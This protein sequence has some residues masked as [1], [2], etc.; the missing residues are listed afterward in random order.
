[1]NTMDL[2]LY[3]MLQGIAMFFSFIYKIIIIIIIFMFSHRIQTLWSFYLGI[4]KN[5]LSKKRLILSF[6]DW[7]TLKLNPEVIIDA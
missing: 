3:A 2:E 7:K 4:L 6:C 1:M 5:L